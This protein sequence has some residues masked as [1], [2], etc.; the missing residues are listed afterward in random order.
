MI[1]SDERPLTGSCQ[2]G[3]VRYRITAEPMAFYACHCSEC[4]KQSGSIH[5]LSLIVSA[6][7]LEVIEGK[8]K[9]WSRPTDQGAKMNCWFCGDCGNRLYHQSSAWP[10]ETSVKAG[11]LDQPVD[12][13]KAVHI[14]TDSGL[15]SVSFPEESRHLAG[16]PV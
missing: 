14:W 5:G 2:C 12:V 7:S 4:R 3:A 6:D 16:E 15:P 10:D 13:T 1:D 8:P 9:L 11:T